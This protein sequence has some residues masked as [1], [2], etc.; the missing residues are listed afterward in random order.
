MDSDRNTCRVSILFVFCDN[1]WPLTRQSQPN[2]SSH[3][4]AFV[5]T[6]TKSSKASEV[7]KLASEAV[8]MMLCES[9]AHPHS[10]AATSQKEVEEMLGEVVSDPE[11]GHPAPGEPFA[12]AYE[13]ERPYLIVTHR[14]QQEE[15]GRLWPHATNR[16]GFRQPRPRPCRSRSP[17]PSGRCICRK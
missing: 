5:D 8:R 4:G 9:G 3:L 15:E 7:Q 10:E 1:S 14:S 17:S 11:L 13:T 2:K 6:P 16:L 12:L